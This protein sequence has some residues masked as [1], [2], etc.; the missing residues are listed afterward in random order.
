M[1]PRV[2]YLLNAASALVEHWEDRLVPQEAWHRA[3]DYMVTAAMID[4]DAVMEAWERL[5]L[6]YERW[7]E[8]QLIIDN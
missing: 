5:A 3:D 6:E 4:A 8:R 7:K 1:S 2:T